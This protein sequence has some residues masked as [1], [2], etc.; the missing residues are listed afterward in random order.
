M[1]KS[2]IKEYKQLKQEIKER[3]VRVKEL[4]T[5]IIESLEFDEITTWTEETG[6]VKVSYGYAFT[7]DQLRIDNPE[8]WREF[9]TIEMVKQ[10][11][12]NESGFKL[13]HPFLYKK[14]QTRL[15]PRLTVK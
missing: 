15:S 8:L 11:T 12:F 14:Y 2:E 1:L 6:T 4:R 7:A 9:I 10:T 5:K 13:L 3:N